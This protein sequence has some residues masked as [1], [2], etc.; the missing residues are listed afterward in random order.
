MA[1]TP[2]DMLNYVLDNELDYKFLSNMTLHKMDYSIAEIVD[3]RFTN[4]LEVIRLTSPTYKLNLEIKDDDIITAVKNGLYVSSFIS[5]HA[6]DYQVH[7]LV[8]SFPAEMKPKFEDE[9]ARD[10]VNYMILKTIIALRLDSEA[11]IDS[12]VGQ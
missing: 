8:H 9:I 7:F 3:S 5:R 4:I 10:V 1:T 6:D 11:K 2:R 12:Y